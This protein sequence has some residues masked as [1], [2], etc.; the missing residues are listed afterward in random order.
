MTSRIAYKSLEIL[1]KCDKGPDQK[2]VINNKC[3]LDNPWYAVENPCAGKDTDCFQHVP[4]QF[5]MG[6]TLEISPLDLMS[7]TCFGQNIVKVDVF[8][9]KGRGSFT[10]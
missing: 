4:K 1:S 5:T 6:D 2:V 10:W 8:T 9:D 3:T 7:T